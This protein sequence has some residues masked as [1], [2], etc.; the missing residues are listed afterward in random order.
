MEHSGANRRWRGTL[1]VP[2]TRDGEIG[3]KWLALDF[4]E[5]FDMVIHDD[6]SRC[7]Y[8]ALALF[9]HRFLQNS[10]G[11]RPWKMSP[12]FEGELVT[13]ES[14]AL[15]QLYV[16][17]DWVD[18]DGERFSEWYEDWMTFIHVWNRSYPYD[19]VAVV[20]HNRNIQA[21]YATLPVPGLPFSRSLYDAEGPGFL[22]VHYYKDGHIAPW[23][24]RAFPPGLY[25]IRHGETAFG[26]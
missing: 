16:K 6:L 14:I 21:L 24:E 23:T 13:E 3:A 5:P 7:K 20:T 26:T 17:F 18:G 9:S 10:L 25:L 4:P 22:S 19:R 15:A 1:D 2:L 12:G 11:P 8:T